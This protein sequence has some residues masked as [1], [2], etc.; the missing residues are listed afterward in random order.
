MVRSIPEV[1][2]DDQEQGWMIALGLYRKSL[3][4]GGCGQKLADGISHERHGVTFAARK[5]RC[6]ACDEL[7]IAMEAYEGPRSQALLWAVKRKR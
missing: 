6:R 7:A 2:W 1:E 3:C 4:P 5:I